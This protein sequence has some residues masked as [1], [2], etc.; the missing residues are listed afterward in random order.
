MGQAADIDEWIT[1]VPYDPLWSWQF[2][3]EQGPVR[4]AL[5]EVVADIA[6]FGSTAVPGLAAKPIVDILVGVQA[7][8][9][10]ERQIV[11][12]ARQGYEYLGEAGIP[13]RVAFRKRRPRAFNLAVVAWDGPL[14]RDNLLLRD[15]L[16]AH[17]DDARRYA[18]HKQNVLAE[19]ASTL[20]AYSDRKGAVV[21]DLLRKARRWDD[22]GRGSG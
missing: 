3:G 11:A 2:A 19:G 7:L 22:A 17:P 6:H 21:V 20:L 8:P 9:L 4:D 5:G 15:F 14:W 12:L 16:R 13:G 18:A 1:V 10:R